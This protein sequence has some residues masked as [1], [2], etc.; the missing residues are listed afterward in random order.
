M[1]VVAFGNA[2]LKLSIKL[3]MAVAIESK[4]TN[5]PTNGPSF[6]PFRYDK[7]T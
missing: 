4:R 6:A 3:R 1:G 5:G 7:Y 2:F